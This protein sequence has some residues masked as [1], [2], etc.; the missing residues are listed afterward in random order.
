MSHVASISPGGYDLMDMAMGFGLGWH[1]GQCQ[2]A[3]AQYRGKIIVQLMGDTAGQGPHG[4]YFPQ[5][6]AHH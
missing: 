4:L 6:S 3:E 5:N 2:L 1:Q